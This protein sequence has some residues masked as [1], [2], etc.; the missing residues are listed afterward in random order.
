MI[1]IQQKR[2]ADIVLAPSFQDS[3]L[4]PWLQEGYQL[5]NVKQRSIWIPLE[6][7]SKKTVPLIFLHACCPT[8]HP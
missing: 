1:F 6:E 7:G 5:V 3:F 8:K 4:Q 2:I